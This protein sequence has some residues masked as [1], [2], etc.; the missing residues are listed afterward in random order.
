MRSWQSKGNDLISMRLT[1]DGVPTLDQLLAHL[2]DLAPDNRLGDM[3][4]HSGLVGWT[5]PATD[6]EVADRRRREAAA[7][8]RHE[9]WER[10]RV[11]ELVQRYPE[12]AAAALAG[13]AD[14][15]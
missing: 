2:R 9:E 15:A 8:A 13:E 11:V 7:A 5:R 1:W 4:I 6:E 14:G 3:T 10:K 12:L